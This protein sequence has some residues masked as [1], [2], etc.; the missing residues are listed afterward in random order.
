MTTPLKRVRRELGIKQETI[1]A[2]LG[3]SQAHIS[4]VENRKERASPDLAERIVR[5]FGREQITEEQILY[6]QRFADK[7]AA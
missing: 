1:A 5:F 6:P 3:V 4:C 7:E 2:A